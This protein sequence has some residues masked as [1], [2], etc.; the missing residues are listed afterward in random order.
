MDQSPSPPTGHSPYF[1]DSLALPGLLRSTEG[2]PT[3][4]SGLHLSHRL[5]DSPARYHGH[6]RE[7]SAPP[8]KSEPSQGWF[9]PQGQLAAIG[10][11]LILDSGENKRLPSGTG[12]HVT[13]WASWGAHGQAMETSKPDG[14]VFAGSTGCRTSS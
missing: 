5:L 13:A 10:A 8:S 3:P 1:P 11:V 14:Y 4:A 12:G 2:H 7:T 6:N 9:W